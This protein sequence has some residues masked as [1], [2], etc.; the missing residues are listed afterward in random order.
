MKI[1]ESLEELKTYSTSLKNNGETL[2][3]ID[4]YGDF[5]DGHGSLITKANEVA[6]KTLVTIDHMPHYERYSSE[7][8]SKF[9]DHYKKTTYVSDLKFCELRGVDAVSHIPDTTW[10]LN[11]DFSFVTDTIKTIIPARC[12][13]KTIQEWTHLMKELQPTFDMC[14]EKDFYQK[15]VFE[16]I[17][18]GLGLS[19]QVIGV[20]LVRES[21]GLA[22]SSRN[23]ELS[24]GE[25][26]RATVVYTVLKEI[27]EL[28]SYPTVTKIKEYIKNNVIRSRGSIQYIDVC[29]ENTLQPLDTISEKAV[30]AVSAV[31]GNVG[32]I[33]NIVINSK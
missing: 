26:K 2:A 21:D 5:H 25:R 1:I 14:G 20:P 27:S 19:I 28:D 24:D 23:K 6:D 7:K 22:A 3:S 17:I 33:D 31:F 12:H 16:K 11:E 30:I 9:L 18:E 32:I 4:T 29:S 15:K 8:Y 13:K 10:D